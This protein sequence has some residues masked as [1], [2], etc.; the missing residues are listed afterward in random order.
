MLFCISNSQIL[1]QNKEENVKCEINQHVIL[2]IVFTPFN[3]C[4][5]NIW[6]N[7]NYH[8]IFLAGNKFSWYNKLILSG[9]LQSVDDSIWFDSIFNNWQCKLKLAVKAGWLKKSLVSLAQFTR[10]H[11]KMSSLLSVIYSWFTIFKTNSV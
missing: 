1:N 11:L 10:L 5:S 7:L 9:N 8:H 6:V 4:L 2:D 3:V